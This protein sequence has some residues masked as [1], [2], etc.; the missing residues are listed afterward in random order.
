MNDTISDTDWLNYGH[1]YWKNKPHTKIK[2]VS[3]GFAIDGKGYCRWSLEE[4]E[5]QIPIPENIKVII[6]KTYL[7]LKLTDSDMIVSIVFSPDGS[8]FQIIHL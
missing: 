5:Q 3:F 2:I 7:L 8:E 4:I 6:Q 1:L